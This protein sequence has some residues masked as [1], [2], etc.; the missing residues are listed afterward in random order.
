LVQLLAAEPPNTR[1]WTKKH[2][3]VLTLVKDY[4]N[5]AYY[6]RLFDLQRGQLWEQML[7]VYQ[8]FS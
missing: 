4:S 3:G 6:L 8:I 5:L 1:A 2:T 7:Y